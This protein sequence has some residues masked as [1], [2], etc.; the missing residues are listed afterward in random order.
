MLRSADMDGCAPEDFYS[1]TNHRT[2]VRHGDRWIEVARQRMD[3]AIVIEDGAAIVP[4]A[5][6]L[7][8]AAI[9]IVCGTSGI[10]IVPEFRER[11]RHGFAFMTNEIS[12]ERRV[13]VS[14]GKIA[15]MM[16]DIRAADG[17][18]VF[19]MGPVA[20]HTGGSAYFCEIVRRG[21][22]QAVLSGNALA[23]HDAEHALLG[24]SLGVDLEA[25]RAG[26]GRPPQSHARDQHHQ[27]RRRHPRG[28]R[29]RRAANPASCTSW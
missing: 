21:Y 11:D 10:R 16:R 4:Q 13:E 1:T 24:T 14:I 25:G 8:D 3:A 9:C 20:V 12:S 18:I 19:V 2:L 7:R 5:A 26:E 29:D 6:R 22:V 23:V 15:A 17:R 27:P 28:G